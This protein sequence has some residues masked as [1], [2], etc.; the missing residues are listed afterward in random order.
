[1]VLAVAVVV[2]HVKIRVTPCVVHV[3]V[4]LVTVL[5]HVTN[6]VRN[7]V[8]DFVETHV[9]KDAVII[10]DRNALVNVLVDAIKHVPVAL[11]IVGVHVVTTVPHAHIVV[12][13]HVMVI[14]VFFVKHIAQ[15]A[16][17]HVNFHV[18]LIVP[19]LVEMI[20]NTIVLVHV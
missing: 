9:V 4:A 20:V 3:V 17:L 8:P 5:N 15:V 12:P 16:K 6:F 18:A 14:A 2:E 11:P 10:A 13:P 19:K 1:M 7:H